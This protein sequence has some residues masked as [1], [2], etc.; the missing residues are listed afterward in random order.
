MVAADCDAES[1]SDTGGVQVRPGACG[2]RRGGRCTLPSLIC[3]T[4][5]H[6]LAL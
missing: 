4:T 2:D 3:S 1:A 6:H 5:H